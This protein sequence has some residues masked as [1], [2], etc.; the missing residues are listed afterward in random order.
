MRKQLFL[1]FYLIGPIFQNIYSSEASISYFKQ[2]K[3]IEAVDPDVIES[4]NDR[5]I[6]YFF[7]ND[8]QAALTDFNYVLEQME[9]DAINKEVIGCALWGRMLVHAY[10]GMEGEAFTDIELIRS[11]MC[12]DI[13]CNNYF[14]FN[15]SSPHAFFAAR[16]GFSKGFMDPKEPMSRS[17]CAQTVRN[18]VAVIKG[19]AACIP[20][21]IIRFAALELIHS[22]EK[23]A[24]RCCE[25]GGL[26]SA[27]IKPLADKLHAWNQKWKVFGIPPDPSWDPDI[28]IR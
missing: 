26:W 21:Q 13:P 18:T 6:S 9:N 19:V 16:E 1:I 5:G 10:L 24:L 8:L 17:E 14:S 12:V 15:L 22:L 4:Y 27:C 2:T 7:D 11:F 23:K 25:T 3:A 20:K 28:V